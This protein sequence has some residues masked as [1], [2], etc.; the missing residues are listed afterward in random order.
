VRP[1]VVEGSPCTNLDKVTSDTDFIHKLNLTYK[2]TPD[3]LVYVTWSKGFRPGGINRRGT[4]DPYGADELDN[5]EFGWK[6][7][8]GPVTFNGSIY[9]QD[10]NGIQLSFLGANGL[11]EI[12]NAGIA[13]IR[14][15]ELDVGYSAGGL[16]VNLNGSYNDAKITRDFCQF[17]VAA[18]PF[19]CTLGAPDSLT[20]DDLLLEENDV[21]APAGTQL[22]LTPKFKG[23]A[24]ARY[25]FPL[26]DWD[27]HIQ[28]AVSHIGSRRS[29]LRNLQNGIKGEF[30]AYTTADF[31]I[32][33]DAGDYR[34]ELFVTNL[35][36]SNG[37]Y[38]SG[39]QCVETTCGD[40]DGG[41][42]SGGVFYDYVIK[43]RTM[44]V[45]IGADF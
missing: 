24:I 22:P 38:F 5:Y 23:N 42:A 3:M 31:S 35:F 39:V 20:D 33:A 15:I 36:D 26:G 13:R 4:L 44:G 6:G 25:E 16:S 34:V 7:V 37:R 41:T 10:W 29:D 27:G 32:G 8:I 12:R 2:V 19:D 45:K 1:P 9:Q 40:P 14:G 30:P 17:A 11:T 28:G 43:P 21:L 18:D